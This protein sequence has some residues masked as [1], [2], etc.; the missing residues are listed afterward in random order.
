MGNLKESFCTQKF[1]V[2][3]RSEFICAVIDNFAC[4]K[5]HP[6]RS[7]PV[8]NKLSFPKNLQIGQIKQG[9]MV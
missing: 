2:Q 5:G 3:L 4:D 9:I 6:Y 7:F 1:S 8:I